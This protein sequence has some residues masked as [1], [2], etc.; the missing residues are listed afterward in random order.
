MTC[1]KGVYVATCSE[2]GHRLADPMECDMC[3]G[4]DRIGRVWCPQCDFC[5]GC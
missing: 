3:R 4:E 1:D 2:C 5:C